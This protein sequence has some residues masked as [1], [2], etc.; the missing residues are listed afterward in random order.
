MAKLNSYVAVRDADGLDVWFGPGQ[1]VPGWAVAKIT[2]P[3]AWA[4]VP[5]VAPA[6]AVEVETEAPVV[7]DKPPARRGRKPASAVEA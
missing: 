2:N 3:A 7:A 1:D 5:E 4:E 6:A